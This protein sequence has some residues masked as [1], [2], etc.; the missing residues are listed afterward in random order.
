[1]KTEI[2]TKLAFR[3]DSS[4]HRDHEYMVVG[5]IAFKTNRYHEIAVAIRQIK[6][7]SDL[8]SEMKW[9][10]FR[11]GYRGIAYFALVDLFFQLISEGKIHF[12]CIVAKFGE[13]SHKSFGGSGPE[14]SVNKLYF[15][16][17]VHKICKQYAKDCYIY[18]YPDRGG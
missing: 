17:L 14:S 12:H 16:L 18:V 2:A 3:C 6:E 1:M 10:K 7:V 4:S 11:G 13:F 15:Q 9:S 8:K 5:G